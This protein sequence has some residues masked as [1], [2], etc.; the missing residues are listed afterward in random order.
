ML[1]D[2]NIYQKNKQDGAK[3][4]AS[5]FW[6]TK[7]NQKKSLMSDAADM[8]IDYLIN[9]KNSS[10]KT[11]ENY[12]FWI[13]KAIEYFNDPYIEDIKLI[14]IL[15]Y[16]KDLAKRELSKKTINYYIIALR[17]FFKF[18]L[19]HDIDCISP[20]KIEIAKIPRTPVN[21]LTEDEI[22]VLLTMPQRHTNDPLLRARD[23]VILHILYGSGLRVSELIW[24]KRDQ[25]IIWE[26][27]FSIV[28]KWWKLRSVFFRKEALEK[29]NKYLVWREDDYDPLIISLS[30]NSYGH[31][32]SR[33]TIEAIVKKYANLA[34]IEKK[35]TP[36]TL[37]HTYATMLLKNW[38]DI[39]S[40]QALLGHSSIVTTQIYTHVDDKFLKHVH[41][42]LD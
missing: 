4:R 34:G 32:L 28:G 35:V 27:Q 18:L 20:E 6:T 25:Y 21:F 40:V 42:L 22:S 1:N 26:K 29:L 39:R 31:S 8:Y 30:K 17:S 41:D 33:N 16:R 2:V 14:D 37:R 36:H 7:K 15:Q 24:L 5:S 11:I 10:P 23:E 3:K 38:A 13:W 9:T 12:Q 19:K